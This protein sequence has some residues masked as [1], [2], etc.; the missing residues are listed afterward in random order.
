MYGDA[1]FA[2]N[3]DLSSQLGYTI[4]LCDESNRCHVLDFSRKKSKRIVRSIMAAEV[5]AFM[6]VF[7]VMTVIVSDYVMLLHK[8]IP[9]IMF[10]D[11]KKLFDNINRGKRT[12]EK[13]LVIDIK[14]AGEAYKKFEIHAIGLIRGD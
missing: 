4:L 6:D 5:Y 3:D 7:D 1:S 11:S 9:V 13:R 8:Q 10:T 2:T 14:S 12:T